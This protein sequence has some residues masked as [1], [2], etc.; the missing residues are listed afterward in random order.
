MSSFTDRISERRKTFKNTVDNEDTRRRREEEAVQ[1]RKKEKEEQMARRRKLVELSSDITGNKVCLDN[2]PL[3][4]KSIPKFAEYLNSA[5]PMTV[6]EAAIAIRKILSVD[7]NPP[8]AEVINAGV[9]PRLKELLADSNRPNIQLEACWSLTNI[10]SGTP[11]Q[12]QAVVDSGVVP[13]FVN[14]LKSIDTSLQEQ[15]VWAVANIAGDRTEYRDGC[16]SVG[17]VEAMCQIVGDSLRSGS[18]Q[19]TRL[20]TWG[21]SNLCRGKP[22]PDFSRISIAADVLAQAIC[23]SNDT[24]VLSDSAWAFSYLTD[25]ASC[26]SVNEI[27]SHL[28]LPRLVSLLAHPSGSVHTPILRVIG[29]LVSGDTLVTQRVVG[30]PGCLPQLKSLLLSNKKSIRKEALWTISNICADSQAHIQSVIESRLME[31]ICEILKSGHAD[32]D[33]KKEAIWCVC[34][35]VTVGSRFQVDILVKRFDFM[36][37]LCDFIASSKD[38]KS[39]KTALDA[40]YTILVHGQSRTDDS[41]NAYTELLEEAGGLNTI[42]DLQQDQSEE[43]YQAAVRIL[44]NFFNCE[45]E[46][47]APPQ[48]QNIV[49][50]FTNKPTVSDMREPANRAHSFSG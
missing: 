46:E 8:I 5:D 6:A 42:E 15:A 39:L 31:R 26:E 4:A 48:N 50:N 16:I 24:E 28:N 21:L 35:T 27:L 29:N 3:S 14:L 32:A 49:F 45:E 36:T 12:T 11:D 40:I 34:N 7:R 44:E 41:F 23:S 47:V 1:I 19:M 20:A 18:V 13:L 9:L 30:T 10:A 22:A 25:S 38:T 43:I 17:T 33:V 2:L 37:V